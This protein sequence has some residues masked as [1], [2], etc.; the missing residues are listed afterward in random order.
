MVSLEK[1]DSNTNVPAAELPWRI[2]EF[3]GSI[4][5]DRRTPVCAP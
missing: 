2:S 5:Y 4:G 1:Q 3:V